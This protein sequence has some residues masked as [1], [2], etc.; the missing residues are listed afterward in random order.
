MGYTDLAFAVLSRFIDDIAAADLKGL[1][2]RTY[3]R[4]VFGS[5]A[6][7]PLTTL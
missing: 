4:A 7:A 6:I 2:D 1:I 5:E 3:T